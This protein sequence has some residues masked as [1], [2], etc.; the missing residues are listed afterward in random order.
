[1][2]K[3]QLADYLGITVKTLLHRVE[4]WLECQT[5]KPFTIDTYKRWKVLNPYYSEILKREL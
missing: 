3:Q 2:G 1:M 5:V 4:I